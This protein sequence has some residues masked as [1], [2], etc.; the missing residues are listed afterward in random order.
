MNMIMGRRLTPP[1]LFSRRRFGAVFLAAGAA[2]CA[3]GGAKTHKAGPGAFAF[4][5][6]FA[7]AAEI[8]VWTFI[9]EILS[10]DTPVVFVMHGVGRNGEEYR[11][12]WAGL[13]DAN[14]FALAV[15]EFSKEKFPGTDNYNLGGVPGGQLA[16][17]A[18]AYIEPLFDVVKTQLGLYAKAYSIYGHSAGAQFVHRFVAFTPRARI[19]R[20]VAA[21]AGWYT[22]PDFETAFPFGL[23]GA[24]IDEAAFASWLASPMT[25]LLGEADNDP[26]AR[27]LRRDADADRQGDNRLARGQY[28]FA[29]GETAAAR[30]DVPFGWTLAYVP[31]VAHDN[32]RMAPHAVLH[33][34][35]R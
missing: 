30:L 9:P 3:R 12:Q 17:G 11:D 2:G 29:A 22:A 14:G 25:I 15:P 19:A 34:L 8:P 24:G 31:G 21:N 4:R 28:F 33:L 10:A 35:S 1:L 7:G 20:A 6:P 32:S 18:Y 5:P 26:A 27:S 23:A 16:S 13:A